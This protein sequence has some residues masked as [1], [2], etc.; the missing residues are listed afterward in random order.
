MRLPFLLLP[1]FT[2]LL[3]ALKGAA[4][5]TFSWSD[6]DR[7][8]NAYCYECHGGFATDGDLDLINVDQRAD[9]A[10]NP[11]RWTKVVH[12]LRSHY[13]PQIGRAHV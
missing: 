10:A 12:A 8:F 2:A 6:A 7:I 13:M 5:E 4:R 1:V 3:V 9:I 11:E